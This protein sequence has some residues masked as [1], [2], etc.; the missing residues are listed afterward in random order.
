MKAVSEAL[1]LFLRKEGYDQKKGASSFTTKETGSR[2]KL[3]IV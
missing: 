1:G 3:P 2:N